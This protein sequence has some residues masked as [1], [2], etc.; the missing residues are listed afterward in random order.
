[1]ESIYEK[2]AK[3]IVIIFAIAALLFVGALGIKVAWNFL[4][5]EV[6]NGPELTFQQAFVGFC[7]TKLIFPFNIDFKK[8][9]G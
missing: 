4:I 7:L 1:M 3:I 9:I 2:L 8:L 6:F 5:P